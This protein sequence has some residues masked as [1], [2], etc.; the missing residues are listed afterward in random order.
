[1]TT[2]TTPEEVESLAE[3]EEIPA[4]SKKSLVDAAIA[5]SKQTGGKGS[6]PTAEQEL[7]DEKTEENTTP[8]TDDLLGRDV[9]VGPFKMKPITLATISLLKEINSPLIMGVQLDDVPN[10]VQNVLEL[11][12]IQK[13]PL[14]D[15]A[16]LVQDRTTFRLR[17]LEMGDGIQP[18]QIEDLVTQCTQALA[19]ATSGQVEPKEP[20]FDSGG[21]KDG[22][23]APSGNASSRHG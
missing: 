21:K 5:A 7:L 3:V 8:V 6:S 4:K 10:I 20:E 17:C 13:L 14:K 18:D 12:L 19:D 11:I 15:A 9:D 1:M 22:K 16:E 2:K 23:K